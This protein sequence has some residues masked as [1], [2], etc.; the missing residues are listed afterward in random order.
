MITPAE[1][2]EVLAP[3]KPKPSVFEA[4]RQLAA[5][6]RQEAE[7]GPTATVEYDEDAAIC[8][9]I[10]RTQQELARFIENLPP[11][12]YIELSESETFIRLRL[13]LDRYRKLLLLNRLE[14]WGNENGY[15]MEQIRE[16][17]NA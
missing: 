11:R 16:A 5:R 14:R 10:S 4:R 13:K 12:E 8:I 9:A 7:R 1:A 2:A 3:T 15:S 17:C 6:L